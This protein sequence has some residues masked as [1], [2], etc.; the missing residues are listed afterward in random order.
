MNKILLVLFAI[1]TMSNPAVSQVYETSL[2]SGVGQSYIIL[3]ENFAKILWRCLGG[4]Q[5]RVVTVEGEY[6][7]RKQMANLNCN[8]NKKTVHCRSLC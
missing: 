4:S 6:F 5:A 8:I 2:T 7:F 1:G 3:N